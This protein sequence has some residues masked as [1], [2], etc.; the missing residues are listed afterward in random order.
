M[1]ETKQLPTREEVPVEKTWDLTTIF[2][3][4]EA[5]ESAFQAAGEKV[6]ALKKYEGTLANGAD[7]FL[8][9]LET[10]L[11]VYREASVVYTYAHLKNDQDT[12]N[13]TYQAMSN[14]A[15]T[16]ITQAQAAASW[17]EPELLEIPEDQLEDYFGENEE[18]DVY[19]HEIKN[20]TAKRPHI[21]SAEIE[22][23]LAQAGEIFDA[24]S[25][26][27]SVLNN[28]DIKFPTVTDEEGNEVQ[29]S[30]G[31][32]GQLLESKNRDVRKEAF[33]AMYET[34]GGLKNTIASTFQ[35]DKKK[36]NYLAK[37]HNYDSARHRAL[38]NNH[39]PEEVHETLIEVVNDNLHLLHRYMELR[40]KLLGVEEL[41]MYDLY[42][43]II[44]EA[45]MKFSYDEATDVTYE[46]LDILGPEYR[47]V[48]ENAFGQRWIDIHENK[49]R[50]SGA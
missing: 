43:S 37:V 41:N 18:L 36:N 16:L 13:S 12:G 29:L 1:E 14:R 25:S 6:E 20:I 42:V 39:I 15:L 30:H 2:E 49:G 26:T 48:L 27:F 3:S 47:E 38:S 9:A 17:F 44:G 11:T 40:K 45:D 21:L 5:W 34:F 4:D 24:P 7:A 28:A 22:G 10:M 46:A 35:A 19:R 8:E 31:L 50:R 33:D 23:I 32:Y